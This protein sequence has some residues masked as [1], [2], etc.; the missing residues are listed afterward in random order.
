MWLGWKLS[1]GKAD[2]ILT[3]VLQKN[4]KSPI[5]GLLYLQLLQVCN[6]GIINNNNDF[7]FC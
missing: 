2:C 5:K 6:K 7:I 1:A 3:A 4:L